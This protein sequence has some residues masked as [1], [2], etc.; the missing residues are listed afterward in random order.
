MVDRPDG[1]GRRAAGDRLAGLVPVRLP[2]AFLAERRDDSGKGP[3][4]PD[5]LEIFD[6]LVARLPVVAHPKL[7][8][9]RSLYPLPRRD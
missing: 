2:D 8:K 1:A 4:G 5:A 6:L 9:H 7:E 3:A